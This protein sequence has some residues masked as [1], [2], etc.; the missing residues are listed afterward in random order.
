MKKGFLFMAIAGIAL[1][2]TAC[3]DDMDKGITGGGGGMQDANNIYR[4]VTSTN[5]ND[6]TS[7]VRDVSLKNDE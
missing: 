5:E 4:S 6:T 2:F 3:E 7:V 1:L